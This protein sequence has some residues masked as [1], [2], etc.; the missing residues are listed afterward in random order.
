VSIW[1]T[2][3]D[4]RIP[5]FI[6]QSVPNCQV[7][8]GQTPLD[9]LYCGPAP[10]LVTGVAQINFQLPTS[11]AASSIM[12]SSGGRSSNPVQIYVQ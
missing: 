1:A 3:W 4:A 10:G 7:Y 2:G 8:A 12:I 6:S 9:V 11:F 5:D